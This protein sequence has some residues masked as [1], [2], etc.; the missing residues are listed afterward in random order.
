M[1]NPHYI[2]IYKFCRLFLKQV[3]CV[4]SVDLEVWDRIWKYYFRIW[5]FLYRIFCLQ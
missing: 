3:L 1:L 2:Y 4:E 5:Y